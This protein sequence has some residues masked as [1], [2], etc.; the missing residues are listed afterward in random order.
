MAI[1][2]FTI[3]Y[4]DRFLQMAGKSMSFISFDPPN[5]Q[6]RGNL[7]MKNGRKN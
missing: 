6:V 1:K 7:S 4:A 2:K 3:Q 5:G